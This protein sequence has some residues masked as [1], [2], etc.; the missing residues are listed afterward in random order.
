MEY[1]NLQLIR[2][3]R[4]TKNGSYTWCKTTQTQAHT[5]TQERDIF[6]TL[7]NCNVITL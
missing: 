2:E 1:C 6:L 3:R 5:Y 4:V 7:R